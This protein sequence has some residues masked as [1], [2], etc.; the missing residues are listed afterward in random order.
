LAKI[1]AAS[2]ATSVGDIL[3]RFQ[4]RLSLHDHVKTAEEL[5][6]QAASG[7]GGQILASVRAVCAWR[8]DA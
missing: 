5:D 2:I 6:C 4:A 1:N 8:D 3:A 7:A